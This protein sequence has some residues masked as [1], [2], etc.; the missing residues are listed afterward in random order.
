MDGCLGT[1]WGDKWYL[2]I[3][4]TLW[5]VPSP[6][7]RATPAPHQSLCAEMAEELCFALRC[8]G[9]RQ[10]PALKRQCSKCIPGTPYVPAVLDLQP[11]NGLHS[12]V[13]LYSDTI[14]LHQFRTYWR[15][16]NTGDVSTTTEVYLRGREII[17]SENNYGCVN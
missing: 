13:S 12:H 6:L 2:F 4:S 5:N 3:F 10:R 15:I 11:T 7:Q 1:F 16:R 14:H 17:S 9:S 8:R